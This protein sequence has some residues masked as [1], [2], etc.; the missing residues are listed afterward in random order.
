VSADKEEKYRQFHKVLLAAYRAFLEFESKVGEHPNA[1]VRAAQFNE[2]ILTHYHVLKKDITPDICEEYMKRYHYLGAPLDS[3][4][5]DDMTPVQ[6]RAHAKLAYGEFRKEM[7][8]KGSKEAEIIAF[9][10]YVK[11]KY[12]H[13]LDSFSET[14]AEEAIANWKSSRHGGYVKYALATVC[15]LALAALIP[16]MQRPE[17]N[18]PF[19]PREPA[20]DRL[21]NHDP[22]PQW[23]QP[24]IGP[25]NDPWRPLP[26]GQFIGQDPQFLPPAGPMDAKAI[27]EW[28]KSWQERL[29]KLEEEQRRKD[30]QDP[31][32]QR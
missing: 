15:T 20:A 6:R 3:P 30:G 16:A 10:D 5:V 27:E 17:D 26:P 12:P 1:A 31:E 2:F 19:K 24:A 11:T 29:K 25:L 28:N 18:A 21:R 32:R 14:E 23:R 22:L 13:T 8:F 4:P 7:N 9:T